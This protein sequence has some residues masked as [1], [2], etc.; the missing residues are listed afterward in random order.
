MHINPFGLGIRLKTST[1]NL[2]WNWKYYKMTNAVIQN[3]NLDVVSDMFAGHLNNMVFY[4]S[5]S[6]AQVMD[7]DLSIPPNESLLQT[8]IMR[9]RKIMLHSLLQ[10]APQ[11][12]TFKLTAFD[13]DTNDAI[14]L[15][16]RGV[17]SKLNTIFRAGIREEHI[18]CLET[19]NTFN[20]YFHADAKYDVYNWNPVIAG[21]TDLPLDQN[22]SKIVFMPQNNDTLNVV[23]F[24]IDSSG[25]NGRFYF[26]KG[27]I[28][29]TGIP[30]QT[31]PQAVMSY[32]IFPNPFR[33]MLSIDL[34]LPVPTKTNIQI[35]NVKGQRVCSLVSDVLLQKGEH[36]ISWNGKDEYGKAMA[37]GIYF[38]KGLAGEK[39]FTR[40]ILKY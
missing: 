20:I 28:P 23:I 8:K 24:L 12:Y 25:Q 13:M 34:K 31:I 18:A 30:E 22:R 3:K 15:F 14:L 37:S 35:Y 39:A 1:N 21:L 10:S 32:R 38:L 16:S 26:A 6:A 11:D 27:S 4:R 7:M 40:K 36:T 33:N 29:Y 5:S 9:E 17:A 2:F 19:D